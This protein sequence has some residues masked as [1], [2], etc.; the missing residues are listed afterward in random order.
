[1]L[2]FGSIALSGHH[3]VDA[4]KHTRIKLFIKST[5][6]S[7]SVLE[8]LSLNSIHDIGKQI[9]VIY[10]D[11]S[12]AFDKVSHVRVLRASSQR[13]WIRRKSLNVV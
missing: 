8:T 6:V 10:L 2:I 11:M 3:C 7:S 5:E 9:D 1:V 13:I 12:K 4:S